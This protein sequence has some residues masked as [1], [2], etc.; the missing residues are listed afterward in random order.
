MILNALSHHYF[1]NHL[2]DSHKEEIV[3]KMFYCQTHDDQFIFKQGDQASCYFI[4]AKGQCE[5]IING[6]FKKHLTQGEGFGELALL[7]GAPRSASVRSNGCELWAIDRTTFR[8]AVEQ[9]VQRDYEENRKFIDT[10][11]FFD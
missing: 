5:I 3:N 9:L 4:I 6:E 2:S 1:F 8:N 11:K 10:I 7:Y